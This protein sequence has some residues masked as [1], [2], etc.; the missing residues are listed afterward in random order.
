MTFFTA[1]PPPHSDASIVRLSPDREKQGGSAGDA[2]AGA[3]V[4]LTALIDS[5]T[6]MVFFS[7]KAGPTAAEPM[8]GPLASPIPGMMNTNKCKWWVF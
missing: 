1:V 8:V 3:A 6:V 2:R 5:P 7:L 4:A